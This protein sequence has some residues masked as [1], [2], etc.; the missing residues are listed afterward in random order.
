MTAESISCLQVRA[1]SGRG[2]SE[3]CTSPK[4]ALGGGTEKRGGGGGGGGGLVYL[5]SLRW[6]GA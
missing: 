3:A 1:G 6:V 2:D 5:V 4:S